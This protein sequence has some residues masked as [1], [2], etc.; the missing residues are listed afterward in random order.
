VRVL[1]ARASA[2]DEVDRRS[3][4]SGL[5]REQVEHEVELA[6]VYERAENTHREF[7]RAGLLDD[8]VGALFEIADE[9]RQNC[10]ITDANKHGRRFSGTACRSPP[11]HTLSPHFG[12]TTI[13][14]PSD[15]L[16]ELGAGSRK[17]RTGVG[18]ER[19][20]GPQ[21]RSFTGP[22]WD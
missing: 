15:S 10:W 21:P 18:F 3:R 1:L 4:V 13:P 20:G 16:K 8:V 14:R 19:P 17:I 12:T 7:I 11:R 2:L 5:P 6:A 9:R 22:L